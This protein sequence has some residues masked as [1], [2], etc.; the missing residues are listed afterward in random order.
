M[1]IS[2]PSIETALERALDRNPVVALIDPRQV[3]KTTLARKFADRIQGTIYLDFERIGDRRKLEDAEA[4]LHAQVGHLI[5]LD[6]VQRLPSLFAELRGIVDDR[7]AGGERSMQFLFLGSASLDLIRNNGRTNS[8][9]RDA[10][11]RCGGG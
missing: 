5:V 11:N 8:L 6:E 7:R 10:A 3:G 9:S 1:I 4:F 2:R